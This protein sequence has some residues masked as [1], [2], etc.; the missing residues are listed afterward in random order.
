MIHR[1]DPLILGATSLAIGGVGIICTFFAREYRD[2]LLRINESRRILPARLIHFQKSEA[3][4]WAIRISGVIGLG[5][6]IL[7]GYVAYTRS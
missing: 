2:L 5:M 4:L 1:G 3:N 6:A 7:L